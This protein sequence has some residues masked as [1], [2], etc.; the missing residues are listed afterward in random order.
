MKHQNII[1]RKPENIW[2][3]GTPIKY[4]SIETHRNPSKLITQLEKGL[5]T[6][7][8]NNQT[9]HTSNNHIVMDNN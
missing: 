5:T 2:K 4:K 6:R 8:K 1:Q 3:P 7:T 9:K